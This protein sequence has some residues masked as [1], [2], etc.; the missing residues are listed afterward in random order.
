M[1]DEGQ[2]EAAGEPEADQ[3]EVEEEAPAAEEGQD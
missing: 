1:E 2:A 3:G